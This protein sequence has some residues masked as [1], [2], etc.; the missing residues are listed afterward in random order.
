MIAIQSYGVDSAADLRVADLIASLKNE[1]CQSL[2]KAPQTSETKGWD[3]FA[4]QNSDA[5]KHIQ[6][7]MMQVKSQVVSAS[8][9]ETEGIIHPSASYRPFSTR[10]NQ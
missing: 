9:K 8:L 2:E 5:M 6:D 7:A 10:Y 1:L 4:Y 3:G